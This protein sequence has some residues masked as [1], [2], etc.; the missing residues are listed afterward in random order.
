M[1]VSP[2]EMA[3]LVFYNT[4][5]F[6]INITAALIEI[7]FELMIHWSTNRL[8]QIEFGESNWGHL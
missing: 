7:I 2:S 6:L 4:W 5:C 3:P 8:F 1:Y